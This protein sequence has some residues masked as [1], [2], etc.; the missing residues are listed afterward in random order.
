M[1]KKVNKQ[2]EQLV[3][4]NMRLVPHILKKLGIFSSNPEYD[5]L[6]QIG[7]IGLMKAAQTF[8][9]NKAKFATYASTCIRNEIGMY[10]R[11]ENKNLNIIHLQDEFYATKGDPSSALTYEEIIEDR[12]ARFVDRV[13]DCEILE[14]ILSIIL[15]CLE[16]RDRVLMLYNISRIPQSETSKK[17]NKEKYLIKI[18]KE[19]DTILFT[20]NNIENV[21]IFSKKILNKLEK[22]ITNDFSLICKEDKILIELPADFSSFLIVAEILEIVEK[23]D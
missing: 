14:N 4:Q 5:D 21:Y 20:I 3:L 10:L 6:I 7:N 8:D 13:S 12:K 23:I 16:K 15:N 11:K 1:N 18:I 2:Q 19:K 9:S 22:N 17:F